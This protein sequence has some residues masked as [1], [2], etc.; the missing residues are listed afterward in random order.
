L[1]G[2]LL[3][4][5]IDDEFQV[6]IPSLS[7]HEYQILKENILKGGC[8]DPLVLWNKILIDGYNRYK[9]CTE[10]NLKFNVVEKPFDSR[11]DVYIWIIQN[12]LGRRNLPHFA[13]AELGVKL[14]HFFQEKGLENKRHAGK[15]YG[16]SDLNSIKKLLPNSA[17]P[18][19]DSGIKINAREEVAKIA[20]VGHDTISK[21]E[22]I[23]EIASPEEIEKARSW[24]VSVN[25]MYSTIKRKEKEEQRDQHVKE[26]IEK[27]KNGKPMGEID[28]LFQTIVIDPPWDWRDE[29]DNNQFGRA[30][31]DYATMPFEEILNSPVIRFADENCHLYLWITNRSLPKGFELI[32]AWGFRYITCLTW[33]K[34]SFGMGNYFRGSTEQVLFA[35]KRNMPI[36]R[37]DVGTHFEAPRGEK[38]SDK[39]N[40]VYDLIESCSYG[41]YLEIFS[42]HQR[43]GWIM[44][45]AD[46]QC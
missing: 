26:N 10:H 2:F 5:I 15:L 31:P 37:H 22:K 30:K 44:W 40:K 25:Q 12:Q 43:D 45:G 46:A 34:P 41:P 32:E 4:L 27:V 14:K 19:L 23:L 11:N 6:L 36:K 18:I 28:S 39:P 42:R 20:G 1:G 21:V 3:D 9:I 33:V 13:R 7:S 8:R 38:H 17:K 24:E 16:I 35:I 29:N